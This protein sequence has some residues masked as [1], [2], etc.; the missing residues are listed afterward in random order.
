MI[1]VQIRFDKFVVRWNGRGRDKMKDIEVC[2]VFVLEKDTG[3]RAGKHQMCWKYCLQG[4]MA[5]VVLCTNVM[6]IPLYYAAT[7]YASKGSLREM[8]GASAKEASRLQARC[9][10]IDGKAFG[11]PTCVRAREE[12]PIC[13]TVAERPFFRIVPNTVEV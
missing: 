10:A 3:Q 9:R 1:P 2:F 7:V 5:S 12:P 11:P 13:S 4:K 6:M 8:D